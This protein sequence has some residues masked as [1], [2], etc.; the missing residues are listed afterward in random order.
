M[1]GDS[2]K[3]WT[4]SRVSGFMGLH[5]IAHFFTIYQHSITIYSLL[6]LLTH[7]T[8]FL[9]SVI[10]NSSIHRVWK[11]ESSACVYVFI[12]KTLILCS[13]LKSIALREMSCPS[14]LHLGWFDS[15]KSVILKEVTKG[16][17]KYK[18]SKDKTVIMKSCNATQE[19]GSGKTRFAF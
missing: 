8:R 4:S 12:T 7:I 6:T 9:L 5:L 2:A 11:F 18:I 14:K 10:T 19:H 3:H 15:Q 1:L 16:S 17:T 13:C